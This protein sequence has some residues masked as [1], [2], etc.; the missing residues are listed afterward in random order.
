MSTNVDQLDWLSLSSARA[1]RRQGTRGLRTDTPRARRDDPN[2]SHEA[3][4]WVRRSGVLKGHQ[5][6]VLDTVRAHPGATYVEIA[7]YANIERHAVARRLKE[8]EPHH[9]R[10]GEE[11]K[12]PGPRP[13]LTWWPVERST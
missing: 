7:G 11:V 9:I 12:R 3:A 2:S 1:N 5:Q 10:R 8:L 4:D 13:L 6:L